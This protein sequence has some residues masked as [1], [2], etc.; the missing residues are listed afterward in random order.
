MH[1]IEKMLLLSCLIGLSV[2]LLAGCFSAKSLIQKSN[3]KYPIPENDV[4]KDIPYYDN[5][6]YPSVHYIYARQK[7]EAMGLDK[8]LNGY[9]DL[10]IRVWI[11]SPTGKD[12]QDGEMIE[13]RQTN[14]KWSGNFYSMKTKFSPSKNEDKVVEFEKYDVE[15]EYLSWNEVLAFLVEE[16]IFELK[17]LDKLAAYQQLPEAQKGYPYG[18][19]VISFEIATKNMYRFYHYFAL[20]KFMEIDEVRQVDTIIRFLKQEF[21]INA[22]LNGVSNIIIYD[23]RENKK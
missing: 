13:I 22:L 19:S 2:L 4:H 3:E 7:E 12:I 1:K 15:P 8:L 20:P 6:T 9:D 16:G 17:S 14:E 18:S 5:N 21:N 10:L 11:N 23:L